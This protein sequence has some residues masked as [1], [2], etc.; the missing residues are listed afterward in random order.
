MESLF[1]FKNKRERKKV[2][3]SFPM[4]RK[5]FRLGFY[6]RRPD[7]P[8]QS[9][10]KQKFPLIESMECEGVE[11]LIMTLEPYFKAVGNF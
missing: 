11:T 2:E 4:L 9:P 6:L 8:K 10:R 5:A 7:F 1:P 3:F